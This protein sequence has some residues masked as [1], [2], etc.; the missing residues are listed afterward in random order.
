MSSSTENGA[1]SMLLAGSMPSTALAFAI[2]S[3]SVSQAKCAAP[4]FTATSAPP[5]SSA[6]ISFFIAEARTCGP[7]IISA[8]AGLDTITTSESLAIIAAAPT[9]GP[10]TIAI[11][12]TTP[13]RR[14]M[15]A[16]TSAY[17][18]SAAAPSPTRAPLLSHMAT[19]GVPVLRACSR[20]LTIFFA[21]FAPIAPSITAKSCAKTYTGRPS[22][23]PLPATTPTFCASMLC[24]TKLPPS[25]SIAMRSR[26]VCLPLFFCCST[27]AAFSSRMACLRESTLLRS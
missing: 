26:A 16:N 21:C 22:T 8:P 1:S 15:C 6:L 17:A 18:S 25:S 10:S 7:A 13:L 24:S 19:T 23:V 3:A 27:P 2:A 14:A 20:I 11:I 4:V 12:G 5:S 9:H